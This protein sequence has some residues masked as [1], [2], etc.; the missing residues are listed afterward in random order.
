MESPFESP[1]LRDEIVLSREDSMK[2]INATSLL[3][4]FAGQAVAQESEVVKSDITFRNGDTKLA[5]L[6][7]T[8]ENEEEGQTA[9]VIIQGSGNSDRTNAWAYTIAKYLASQGHA[10]ILPDKR[11][12]GQSQGDWRTVSMEVL[13]RDA[14]AAVDYFKEQR[15][16]QQ[17]GLVGLSQGGKIAPLAATLSDDVEFVVDISGAATSQLSGVLH[18]MVNTAKNAGLKTQDI[19]EMV[20]LHGLIKNY[21]DHG[22]WRAYHD[23]LETFKQGDWAEFASSFPDDPDA[24]LWG[25]LKLNLDYRPIDYW[26]DVEVPVFVAYGELDEDDNVPVWESVFALHDCFL[27]TKHRQHKIMVYPNAGHGLYLDGT[28][29]FSPEFIDDLTEWLESL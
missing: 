1:Q 22:D 24:W 27:S 25:W 23:R 28:A 12:W 5:G 10:V 18:E 16:P 4:L 19:A 9:I 3:L 21:I 26:K 14:L 2:L 8:P 20:E 17:I 7:M 6:L 13:A 11:G 29:Q 15:D